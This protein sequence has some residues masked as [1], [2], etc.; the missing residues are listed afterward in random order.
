MKNGAT[1]FFEIRVRRRRVVGNG[2]QLAVLFGS[3]VAGLIAV[4]CVFV[5]KGVNPFYAIG[6]IFSDS[7]GSTYGI[8]ETI[9][10]AIPLVI[11][12]AGLVLAFR[13][14]FW[15]IGAEGQLLFGAMF[16]TWV[17]LNIGP[18]APSIIVIPLMFIA[19][20]IGGALL[21]SI[22]ALLKVRF[23]VNEVISTLMLN[24]VAAEFVQYLI[25]GPWK[26]E[27]QYGFPYTDDFPSSAVLGLAGNTRIHIVTLI[28]AIVCVVVLTALIYRTRFGYEVRVTGENP[29]AAR[30]AGIHTYKLTI[31]LMV[32]SGGIAGLAGVGEVAGVHHHLSYPYTISA[33]YGFTAIIVAWLSR[34]NPMFVIVSG[35]FFAGIEV[36]GDAIQLSLGLPAA[37][38]EVFNG[39]ILVF[40]IMGEYFLYHSVTIRIRPR[41][42]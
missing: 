27:T 37:T 32:V 22:P 6:R 21:G 19:G 8:Y 10:K 26:G 2:L 31:L 13:A 7:F 40:L 17:A 38:V 11:I 36:G 5:I 29:D 33:G 15:N 3:L 1:R 12:G 25:V 42:K 39:V 24:Y 20:F 4:G 41:G 23:G 14:K 18:N 16:G 9:A 35:M 30:Y 28:L 34:L